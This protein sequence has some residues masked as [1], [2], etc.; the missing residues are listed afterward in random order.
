MDRLADPVKALAQAGWSPIAVANVIG[1]CGVVLVV[2]RL[3]VDAEP[4]A[5]NLVPLALPIGF[6]LV[7]MAFIAA[8]SGE[9]DR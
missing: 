7:C 2:L 9:R 8:S 3:P 4:T 5:R 6:V 1:T